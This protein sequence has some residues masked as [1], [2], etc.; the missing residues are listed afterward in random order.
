[1]NT[2]LSTDKMIALLKY[3]RPVLTHSDSLEIGSITDEDMITFAGYYISLDNNKNLNYFDEYKTAN[4][5]DI[6][7]AISYIFDEQVDYSKV[8]FKVENN[9]IYIPKCYIS[10]DMQ[11][12]KFNKRVYDEKQQ[13]YISYIDCLEMGPSRYTELSP[14]SVTEYDRDSVVNTLVFKYR[15]KDG[16]KVLLAFDSVINT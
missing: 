9:I 13:V 15:I 10:T 16:R 1:M 14:D 7:E 6:E 5:T 3:A 12:Y 2:E 8:S 11:V 4:I